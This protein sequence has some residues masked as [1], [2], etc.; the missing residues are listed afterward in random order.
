M[1]GLLSCAASSRLTM[2]ETG[3]AIRKKGNLWTVRMQ[4]TETEGT[5]GSLKAAMRVAYL[6]TDAHFSD[7]PSNWPS[8]SHEQAA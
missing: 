4:G 3:F 6:L 1:R 7:D 2:L 5:F 8:I